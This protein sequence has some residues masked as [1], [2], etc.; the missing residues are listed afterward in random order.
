MIASLLVATMAALA[1]SAI[2]SSP[3]AGRRNTT[4]AESAV[5]AVDLTAP[6]PNV[7]SSLGPRAPR[8]LNRRPL[9]VSTSQPPLLQQIL[10]CA[11]STHRAHGHTQGRQGQCTDG[12][13]WRAGRCNT[14]HTVC[15]PG[16]TTCWRCNN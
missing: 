6:R 4:L 8:P 7:A 11:P 16:G 12:S 15:G 5:A 13:R 3:A 9:H 1:G 10:H 14:S 2:T